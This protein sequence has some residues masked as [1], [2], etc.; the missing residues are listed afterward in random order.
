MNH[1]MT[2]QIAVWFSLLSSFTVVENEDRTAAITGIAT[3]WIK[4]DLMDIDTGT[5]RIDVSTALRVKEDLLP[6]D[7]TLSLRRILILTLHLWKTLVLSIFFLAYGLIIP[8]RLLPT[9]SEKIYY[10]TP[11]GKRIVVFSSESCLAILDNVHR[12]IYIDGTFK[13]SPKH[14]K[15]IWIIRGHVGEI[16]I[17]LMYILIEDKSSPS[18]TQALEILKT[19]CPN[20]DS[21]VF[22]VDF[23]KSEHSALRSQFPNALIKG[24]LFHWK[25]CLLRKFRKIPGYTE[26]ELMK[27][28]L[29]AVYGLALS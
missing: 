10:T 21:P 13:T 3:L 7:P 12:I 6:W 28:N 16:C 5:V 4:V 1:L 19:H 14:F 17:P 29:H 27:S 20:F 2:P 26:N 8:T 24:C 11:T 15:Q 22:M 25:Q 9:S 18:Y 23:E